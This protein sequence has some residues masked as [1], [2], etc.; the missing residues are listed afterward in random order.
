MYGGGRQSARIAVLVCQGK[1]PVPDFT[2]IADTGHEKET[3]WAYLDKY[4]QPAYPRSIHRIKASEFATVGLY[5]N[6]AAGDSYLLIPAFTR[7][8]DGKLGKLE[9]YCSN[10]W[11]ARVCDR[12]LKRAVGLKQWVTWIGFASDEPKRF[13]SKR[14][15]MGDAVYFPLVD[16]VPTAKDECAKKVM[17]YGWPEPVHSACYMCPL[18]DD[19]DRLDNT[20]ADHQRAIEFDAALREKD[21]NVFIHRSLK[22][23]SEVVLIPSGEH[24]EP[25]D[26]GLC[27]L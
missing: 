15:A 21:P 17:E 24:K 9:T 13:N 20:P 27:M 19:D 10:E 22:P 14:K 26:S 18:Q 5:R 12:W 25:C 16:T 7:G 11:K 2:I 4:V 6:T 23:Y 8:E 1:L 3:T